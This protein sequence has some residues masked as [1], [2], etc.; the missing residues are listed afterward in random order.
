MGR[1]SECEGCEAVQHIL[2]ACRY[3]AM[4]D[5]SMR[6]CF[7]QQRWDLAKAVA[8]WIPGTVAP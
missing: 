8:G 6:C 7:T 3:I 2:H 1:V 4:C 5:S